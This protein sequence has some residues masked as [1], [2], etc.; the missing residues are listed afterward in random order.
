MQSKT[1]GNLWTGFGSAGP[2]SFYQLGADGAFFDFSTPATLFTDAA[3]TTPLTA[4]GQTIGLACDKSRVRSPVTAYAG[5][6]ASAGLRPTWGRGPKSRRNMY[7]RSHLFD[8]AAWVKAEATV[9]PGAALAPDGSLS[10]QLAVPSVNAAAHQIYQSI[11]LTNGQTYTVS[12]YAKAAG[13]SFVNLRF[14]GG[15]AS[16]AFFNLATGAV[17]SATTPANAAIVAIGDGWYRCSYTATASST[18]S[19]SVSVNLATTSDSFGLAGNGTSGIYLWAAQLETGALT[20]PP[21]MTGNVFD[22]T[23]PGQ[24][25]FGYARLDGADD[26]LTVTLPSAITGD[27]MICG[28]NGSWIEAG[29]TLPSG[30]FDLGPTGTV[31]TPGVLRALGDLVGVVIIGRTTTA[32]E[33]AL[34][35]RYFAARGAAGWLVA[36]AEL[37]NNGAFVDGTGW[38]NS[39]TGTGTAVISGGQATLTG[40]DMSNRGAL[41]LTSVTGIT[42]GQPYMI[43]WQITSGTANSQVAVSSGGAVM[44]R[45]GASVAET[46]RAVFIAGATA[47]WFSVN[48]YGAGAVVFDNFSI[49]PLTVGA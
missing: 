15:I 27:L 31:L 44:D 42:I 2:R 23:E 30:A 26:K 1:I 16:E 11:A 19:F 12:V 5:V 45:F 48:V 29:V 43:Q 34:A 24:P 36:G 47:I 14:G 10:A 4:P 40:V 32:T 39:S 46:R 17:V 21:Q 9:S 41:L 20:T 22:I 35:L 49:K 18:A 13:Y 3:G 37:I 8:N 38:S 33:R 25:A 28:R 6:Q 7:Q